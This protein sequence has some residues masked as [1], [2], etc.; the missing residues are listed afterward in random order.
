MNEPIGVPFQPV[1][2]LEL[3]LS[4]R[5]LAYLDQLVRIGILGSTREAV[6]AHLLQ[7]EIWKMLS[8]GRLA[9]IELKLDDRPKCPRCGSPN[10]KDV[11]V[12]GTLGEM[13]CSDCGKFIEPHEFMPPRPAGR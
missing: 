9:L 7:A 4:E 12:M 2:I 13:Q 10:V 8:D 5:I 1:E 3:H 6:V 11:L